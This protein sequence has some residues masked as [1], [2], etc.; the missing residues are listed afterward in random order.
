MGACFVQ[1]GNRFNGSLSAVSRLGM[2]GRHTGSD[3]P[4][5]YQ[6]VRNEQKPS[7]CLC[8]DKRGAHPRWPTIFVVP[9]SEFAF[10]NDL[11]QMNVIRLVKSGHIRVECPHVGAND[12]NVFLRMHVANEPHG[13]GRGDE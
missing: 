3:R 4:F 5:T 2:D 1:G 11:L 10:T 6:Q 8:I 7:R 12:S 9:P 13:C